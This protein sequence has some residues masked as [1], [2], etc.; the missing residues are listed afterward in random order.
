MRVGTASITAEFFNNA[1][2]FL[3]NG[4]LKGESAL[5]KAL[6]K[7]SVDYIRVIGKDF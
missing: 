5:S 4:L 3:H 1:L 6:Y 7:K 2:I